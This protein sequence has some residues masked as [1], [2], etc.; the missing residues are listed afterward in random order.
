MS[1]G[2]DTDPAYKDGKSS[3]G[4]KVFFGNLP[5]TTTWE[6]LKDWL[7]KDGFEATWTNIGR[8]RRNNRSKGF[9]LAQFPDAETAQKCIEEMNDKVLL[10]RKIFVREDR[11]PGQRR[12]RKPEF[13]GDDTEEAGG[14]TGGAQEEAPKAKKERPKK[15]RPKVVCETTRVF[16]GN[17][18]WSVTWKELKD[19]MKSAGE[20]LFCD[21]LTGTRDRSMGCGLVEYKTIKQAQ[22]AVDTLTDTSIND[23][24]IYVREDRETSYCVFINRIP[25]KMTWQDLKDMCAKYGKVLRSDRNSKGY[26]TVR[27]EKEEDAKKCIQGMNGQEYEGRELE[28]MWAKD[29]TKAQAAAQASSDDNKNAEE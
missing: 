15:E 28:A 6:D 11:E 8:D 13:R 25:S 27:F 16:V 22:K 21:V 10:E 12:S 9:G 26:G 29:A 5:W 17:L 7:K 19:H 3:S 14:E 1:D 23:R 24:K 4:V 20:I 2:H 18:A